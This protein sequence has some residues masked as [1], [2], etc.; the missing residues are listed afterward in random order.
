M[1][2]NLF[3]Q[4]LG[5]KKSFL[6]LIASLIAIVLETVSLGVIIPLFTFYKKFNSQQSMKLG[7]DFL[8]NILVDISENELLTYLMLVFLIVYVIKTLYMIWFAW[9]KAFTIFQLDNVLSSK[10]LSSNLDLEFLEFKKDNSGFKARDVVGEVSIARN[11]YLGLINIIIDALT[12]IFII[13]VLLINDPN[14]SLISFSILGFSVLLINGSLRRLQYRIGIFRKQLEQRRLV[15]VQ[16][17]FNLFE[18]IKVGDLKNVV[19]EKFG[20][21]NNSLKDVMSKND[22]YKNFPKYIIELTGVLSIVIYVIL[23]INS[24]LD[25]D[26]IL[27]SVSVFGVGLIKLLPITNR[28]SQSYGQLQ[29]SKGGL[30]AVSSTIRTKNELKSYSKINK[31]PR[32]TKLQITN[33]EFCYPNKSKSL[34]KINLTIDKNGIYLLD[35]VSGKG[36]TTLINLLLGLLTPTSGRLFL[37]NKEYP[38][39]NLKYL[40]SSIRYLPQVV[41]LIDDTVEENLRFSKSYDKADGLKLMSEFNLSKRLNLDSNVGENGNLLSGGQKQRLGIIRAISGLNKSDI[42]ILDEP[43]NNLDTDSIQLIVD[44]LNKVSKEYIIILSSHQIPKRLI[45]TETIKL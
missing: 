35:A 22:F 6:F 14:K 19:L 10:M 24:N 9:F 5:F 20:V 25:I 13:L 23:S 12:F 28:M 31:L 11:Y 45:I 7:L 1:R 4:I 26:E 38:L 41:N 18:Y 30:E 27:K 37:D 39:Q 43:F 33:M 17:Y 32:F 29:F 2:N 8:D 44:Y 3:I 42:V 36:K 21:L 34:F 16:T 40:S 15:H